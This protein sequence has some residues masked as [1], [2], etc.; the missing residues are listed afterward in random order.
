MTQAQRLSSVIP[1]AAIGRPAC[2]KCYA[3]MMLVSI[4]PA[5]AR[6]VDL[7][8][9]KCAVCHQQL[10]TFAAYEDPTKSNV[11]DAG[12]KAI[13]SHRSKGRRPRTAN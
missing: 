9:F 3:R 11:L 5:R 2:P 1:L 4:E 7:H 10:K 8:R 6:G 13:C 12:F